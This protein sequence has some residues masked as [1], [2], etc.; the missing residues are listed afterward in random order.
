MMVQRDLV[1]ELWRMVAEDAAAQMAEVQAAE[2]GRIAGIL[3][4]AAPPAECGPAMPVAPARGPMA[5]IR[6]RGLAPGGQAAIDTGY[7]APGEAIPRKA[8]READAFDAMMRRAIDAHAAAVAKAEAAWT[9]DPD[10]FRAPRFVPPLSSSQIAIGR[11]YQALVERHTAG[12]VKCSSLEAQRG[13]GC[14]GEFMDAY[15][16]E[17]REIDA[18]RRRIGDGAALL[19]RRVRPSARGGAAAGMITDRALVD[20]VCLAGLSLAE[21]L[22]RHGWCSDGKHRAKL[23]TA[24]AGALDRMQGYR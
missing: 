3:A 20:A 11:H 6:P 18:L 21:V 15:L 17:A 14:G 2:A 13:G 1:R 24:L 9:G 8:M 19:V 5:V 4:K 7:M 22:R 10:R 12:G 23:R 16:A